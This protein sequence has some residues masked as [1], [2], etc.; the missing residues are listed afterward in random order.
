M[1][2]GNALETGEW[3]FPGGGYKQNFALRSEMGEALANAL[4]EAD[5]YKNE[6]INFASDKAYTFDEF[7]EA[8]SEAAG[9]KIT[10]NDVS[11]DDFVEGLKQA[12][13]P[14]EQIGMSSVTSTLFANGGTDLTTNDLKNLLG[15]EPTDSLEF[16]KNAVRSKA[17]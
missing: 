10:Y 16:V 1:F 15:R 7:A 5:Q 3:N 8:M 6:V 9:K 12:G 2:W 11:V 17:E 4:A 13:V 14:Q